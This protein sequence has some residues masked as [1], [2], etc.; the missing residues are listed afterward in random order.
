MHRHVVGAHLPSPSWAEHVKSLLF[1]SL[2]KC[3]LYGFL[4]VSLHTSEF[5]VSS[6]GKKSI[7]FVVRMDRGGWAAT[8][9]LVGYTDFAHLFMV[10]STF[11]KLHYPSF[12]ITIVYNGIIL[13]DIFQLVVNPQRGFSLCNKEFNYSSLLLT[14]FKKDSHLKS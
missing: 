10:F 13:V 12:Y 11:F 1:K 6:F 4:R 7:S 8:T 14:S 2:S 9:W 5:I 3:M